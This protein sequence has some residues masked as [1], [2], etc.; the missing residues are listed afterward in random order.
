MSFL[1]RLFN[2]IDLDK[3]GVLDNKEVSVI[4]QK[5]N[6][7]YCRHYDEEDAKI[8]LDTLD[9]NGDGNID[10]DEFTKV[11]KYL[12]E[13]LLKSM[14]INDDD[15]L[16]TQEAE[17]ILEKLNNIFGKNFEEEDRKIFVEVIN[18]YGTENIS[19]KDFKNALLD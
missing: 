2:S 8:F 6:K 14:Q 13:A 17:M 5:F 4:L 3:N 10:F 11:F 19:F 7:C 12:I 15:F 1:V 18:H 16:D 9:I